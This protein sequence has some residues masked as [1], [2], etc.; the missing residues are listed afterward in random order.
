MRAWQIIFVLGVV[1]CLILT[2]LTFGIS[3]TTALAGF[4]ALIVAVINLLINSSKRED[5]DQKWFHTQLRNILNVTTYLKFVTA[6]VWIICLGLSIKFVSEYIGSVNTISIQGNVTT[7]TG[8]PVKNASVLLFLKEDKEI[9]EPTKDGGYFRFDEVDKRNLP[10]KN[11]IRLLARYQNRENEQSFS[12]ENTDLDNIVIK[13]PSGD[14]PF[15]VTYYDISG[16][17]IDFLIQG[18]IDK[19][20]EEK[21]SGQPII[22]VNDVYKEL[23]YLIRKFSAKP[24]YE[25]YFY[26]E[27]DGQYIEY[28]VEKHGEKFLVGTSSSFFDWRLSINDAEYNEIFV[29]N[30]DWNLDF[31]CMWGGENPQDEFKSRLE[32]GKI[33]V[34]QLGLWRYARREDLK[35]YRSASSSFFNKMNEADLF[36]YITKKGLP[37]QFI[38][39]DV[40]YDEC[41]GFI[42]K[43]FFPTLKLQVLVLEN[44]SSGP[45]RFDNFIIKENDADSLRSTDEDQQQLDMAQDKEEELLPTKTLLSREKILIPLNLYFEYETSPNRGMDLDVDQL[46]KCRDMF[47]DI[48]D[49]NNIKYYSLGFDGKDAEVLKVS[50]STLNRMMSGEQIK[51]NKILTSVYG[52]SVRLTSVTVEGEEYPVRAYNPNVFALHM[53][54]NI[55]SCPYVYTFSEQTE[56]WLREDHILY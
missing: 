7:Q 39:L 52:P 41:S 19:S 47:T 45:I 25:T 12:I 28:E 10:S 36:Y 18:K 17:A 4:L 3:K 35:N 21:L 44:I 55:G 46:S 31:E 13:L 9:M 6:G 20:W 33:S 40:G 11:Q 8:D 32:K 23:K 49:E 48:N 38:T 1:V 43:I 27:S 50:S 15:R 22:I 56:M 51:A 24:T 34:T 16:S 37:K 42:K 14:L 2:A 53:G 30:T 5:E 29:P 54:A 26:N